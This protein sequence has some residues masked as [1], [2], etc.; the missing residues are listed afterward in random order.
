MLGIEPHKEKL[1]A[2]I[3]FELGKTERRK[4]QLGHPVNLSFG[5]AC[6]HIFISIE[7][8]RLSILHDGLFFSINTFMIQVNQNRNNYF[9]VTQ[10]IV[11]VY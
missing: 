1:H 3:T 4:D 11:P 9:C 8:W 2:A 5:T 10:H 7:W 6:Q